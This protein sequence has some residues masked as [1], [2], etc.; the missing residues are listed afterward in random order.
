MND[1]T[2]YPRLMPDAEWDEL[3]SIAPA[4]AYDLWMVHYGDN[5]EAMILHTMGLDAHNQTDPSEQ[6]LFDWAYPVQ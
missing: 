2:D 3:A 1:P 4:I 5:H 6:L